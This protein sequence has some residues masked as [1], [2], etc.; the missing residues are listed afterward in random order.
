MK[1]AVFILTL[2]IFA[3]FST[4]GMAN[5]EQLKGN[6]LSD[7]G[8]YTLTESSNVVVINNVAY[9]AWDLQYSGSSE[10]FQVLYS[11]G[12]D[13]QCCFMVR[14]DHFEIQYA[15]KPGGGF[16]VELLDSDKRSLKKR[17]VMSMVNYDQFVNQTV[18][19][20]KDKTVEEYL[21]L[22]ACFMPLLFG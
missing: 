10:K 5:T 2:V 8:S 16:G 20:S 17:E 19:T 9:R 3:L 15:K 1:N 22:V 12:S 14:N 18:L 4:S 21:G 11:P 6:T 13:S 7:F